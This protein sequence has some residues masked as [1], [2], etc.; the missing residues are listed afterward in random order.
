MVF[1]LF[2]EDKD[3]CGRYYFADKTAHVVEDELGLSHGTI[4]TEDGDITPGMTMPGIICS[5]SL[6]EKLQ[7][8]ELY[9]GIRFGGKKFIINARAESAEDKR[10]FAESISKRR[11]ILPATG[12]Y[13][14][15]KNKTKFTFKRTD[16]EPIYLAGFYDMCENRDSFVI[17]TTKANESMKPVHDRMPVMIDK[18]N[19]VSYLSDDLAAMEMIK[20]PMPELSRS[21]DYEQLSFLHFT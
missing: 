6:K 14:W 16:E 19:V 11:C 17:L 13:E 4:R 15:D 7:I 1:L 9:W 2:L 18:R 12:F 10:I 8:A 5:K 21:S 20:E 3:L